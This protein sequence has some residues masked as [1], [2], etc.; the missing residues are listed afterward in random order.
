MEIAFATVDIAPLIEVVAMGASCALLIAAPPPAIR[1]ER[2][3]WLGFSLIA[4]LELLC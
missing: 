3:L 2:A 1:V 4:R